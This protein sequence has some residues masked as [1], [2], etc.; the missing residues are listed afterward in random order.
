MDP[1]ALQDLAQTLFAASRWLFA[2][3]ILITLFAVLT[4]VERGRQKAP[5]YQED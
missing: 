3:L 1:L 4:G 2:A 5:P